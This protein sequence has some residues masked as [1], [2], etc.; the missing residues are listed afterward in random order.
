[1]FLKIMMVKITQKKTF[2]NKLQKKIY[3]KIPTLNQKDQAGQE[4]KKLSIKK[5]LKTHKYFKMMIIYQKSSYQNNKM[6]Q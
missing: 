4:I 5:K 2:L 6:T 3:L 1:M